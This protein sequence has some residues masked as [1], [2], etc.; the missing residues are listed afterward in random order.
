MASRPLFDLDRSRPA[1]ARLARQNASR[2]SC[3]WGLWSGPLERL[4][5]EALRPPHWICRHNPAFMLRNLL[6]GDVRS[7][8]IASLAEQSLA[9]VTE[10]ELTHRAGCTRRAMHLALD[11]LETAGLIVREHRGRRYAIRLSAPPLWPL[12]R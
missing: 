9:D 4:K 2:S 3:K 8:V 11:N 12:K 5:P 10:T 7:K 1:L 6:K